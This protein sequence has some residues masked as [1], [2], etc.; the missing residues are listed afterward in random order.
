MRGLV[1]ALQFLTR[2]PTPALA[3]FEPDWIARAV[4]FF[5][6]VGWIVGAISGAVFWGVSQVLPGWPAAVAALA[7]GLLATGGFHEDGLADTADGLGGGLT[8]E[9]RLAIMKDSRLGSYGALA[10]WAVLSFKA[11]LLARLGDAEGAF[12][13]VLSGGAARALVAPVMATMAYV[14]EPAEA[15][16]KPQGV[17]AWEA[18][19]AL[20]IALAPLLALRAEGGAI[21]VTLAG[22]AVLWLALQARRL[23]GGWTGDVLGGCEALAEAGLLAGLAI[24]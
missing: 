13:L 1:V 15:K 14:R 16:L 17:R 5:P 20:L 12:A 2:L 4:P 10:L 19:L 22:V 24:G 8:P 11:A 18:G 9:R 6:V 3:R 7:A 23:I 21:G